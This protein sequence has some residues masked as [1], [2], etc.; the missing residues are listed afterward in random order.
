MMVFHSSVR[1]VGGRRELLL[2]SGGGG[3]GEHA[4][5]AGLLYGL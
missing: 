2:F 3:R 1:G 4:G 5:C